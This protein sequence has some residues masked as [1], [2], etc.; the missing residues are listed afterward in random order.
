MS[1]KMNVWVK[2]YKEHSESVMF[3][4]QNKCD[5]TLFDRGGIS[6]EDNFLF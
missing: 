6:F 3:K 2:R 1:L 5:S 4:Y